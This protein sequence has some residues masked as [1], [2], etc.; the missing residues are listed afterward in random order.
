MTRHPAPT[1]LEQACLAALGA[2][3]LVA[4][5]RPPGASRLALVALV[6]VVLSLAWR[7]PTAPAAARTGALVLARLAVA[8][9]F[10]TGLVLSL[11]PVVSDRLVALLRQ[12]NGLILAGL[13]GLFVLGTPGWS[14]AAGALLCAVALLALASFD[15]LARLLPLHA[16]AACAVFAYLAV[17]RSQPGQGRRLP[18][19]VAFGLAAASVAALLGRLLPWAQ[20]YMEEATARLL[21]PASPTAYA[22]F[23]SRSSLGDIE[24]LAL[25]RAVVMRVFT[26][27]PSHLRGRVFTHFD[28]RTWRAPRPR[29]RDL[30][31]VSDE[32]AETQGLRSL[33]GRSFVDRLAAREGDAVATRIVPV[34][35]FGDA[36]F[37]PAGVR[38][39]RLEA[40]HLRVDGAGVLQPLAIGSLGMYGVWHGRDRV[41]G[42]EEPPD[43]LL[44]VPPDTDPRLRVLASTLAAGAASPGEKLDRTLTY[45]GTHCRYALAV[46]PFETAQPVAEFVFDKRRGYCEYFASAAAV[47][48]RLQGVPARYV[49]GFAVGD[50]T[51]LGGHYVVRES[52]AHAWIEVSLPGRG[53]VTADPTPAA[54][55]EAVR[56]SLREAGLRG[57]WEAVTAWLA[58]TWIAL[59]LG[60]VRVL[61]PATWIVAAALVTVLAWRRWRRR[62]P[63]RAPMSRAPAHDLSP[64]TAALLAALEGTWAAQGRPR[65]PHRGL[66]E[67]L[68]SWPP[69]LLTEASRAA[70]R[71]AVACVYRARFGGESVPKAEL[72]E[73]RRRLEETARPTA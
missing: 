52:D 39:A 1:R 68:D 58:G 11:Y 43:A 41:A 44:A 8:A 15:P 31:V 59:R 42:W 6:P 19:T 64:E 9:T 34:L 73:V 72:T 62:R 7:L 24:Q 10:V 35:P 20:P 21:N 54:D 50:G 46:G 37:A 69:A 12:V 71:A 38:A 29:L 63:R 27:A 18:S 14:P 48:L 70:G 66:Q 40:P 49:S 23:S 60:D 33:P 2:A 51:R 4:F 53:W 26:D 30:A 13:L 17:G 32:A 57:A 47:L 67:H 25:S 61:G 65:P 45:L 3:A 56:A 16:A 28:G 5:A 22:G 55:Y 36:L